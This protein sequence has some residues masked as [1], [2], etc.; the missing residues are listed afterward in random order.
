[1]G[2][3]CSNMHM[4]GYGMHET[5]TALR[6]VQADRVRLLIHCFPVD[7]KIEGHIDIAISD[8]RHNNASI[9]AAGHSAVILRDRQRSGKGVVSDGRAVTRAPC[10][11]CEWTPQTSSEL[12]I[13]KSTLLSARLRSEELTS[14]SRGPN[15][16]SLW[17]AAAVIIQASSRNDGAIPRSS[18]SVVRPYVRSSRRLVCQLRPCDAEVAALVHIPALL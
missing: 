14:I 1:M 5:K 16:A 2:R 7:A 17:I 9:F 4:D 10:V 11:A 8:R 6:W 12:T 13:A 15:V 18:D 3:L